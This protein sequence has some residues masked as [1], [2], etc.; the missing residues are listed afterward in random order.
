MVKFQSR[1]LYDSWNIQSQAF[2]Q[3][4]RT[5]LESNQPHNDTTRMR[6]AGVELVGV[7]GI[8]DANPFAER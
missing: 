7:P 5:G 6:Q 8:D 3:A 2:Y 1:L 4:M